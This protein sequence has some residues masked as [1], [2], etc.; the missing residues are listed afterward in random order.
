MTTLQK[1]NTIAIGL[2]ILIL[3]SFPII[4]E[5]ALYFGMIS[6][7][8]TGLLQ[9]IIGLI[10]LI[11]EPKNKYYQF[12]ILAVL[13][14]FGFGYYLTAMKFNNDYLSYILYVIP[15]AL[16]IYLSLLVYRIK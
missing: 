5:A 13:I 2:P 3:A 10:L 12:Y 9:F 11:R 6:T 16:A 1:T 7:L 8:I 14:F 15:L 4:K